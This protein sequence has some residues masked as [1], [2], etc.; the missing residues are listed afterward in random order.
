MTV[1]LVVVLLVGK[2]V[3]ISREPG[4]LCIG[5]S[6]STEQLSGSSQVSGHVEIWGEWLPAPFL[7]LAL[8]ISS[9]G[10]LPRYIIFIIKW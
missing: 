4:W 2:V 7:Y 6:I 5:V 10:L 1:E 8:C 9:M 3:R